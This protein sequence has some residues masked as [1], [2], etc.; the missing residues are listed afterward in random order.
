MESMASVTIDGKTVRK[1]FTAVDKKQA[2]ISALNWQNKIF[3]YNKPTQLTLGEAIE[4]YIDS[5]IA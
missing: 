5:K 4:R 1:S 2:E 3:K